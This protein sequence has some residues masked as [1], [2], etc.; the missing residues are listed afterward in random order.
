MGKLIEGA[1]VTYEGKPGLY[2]ITKFWDAGRGRRAVLQAIDPV[3]KEPT[4]KGVGHCLPAAPVG[5]ISLAA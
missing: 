5:K 4:G 1:F 2:K 3:S